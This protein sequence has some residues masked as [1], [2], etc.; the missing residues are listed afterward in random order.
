MARKRA[1]EIYDE[2]EDLTTFDDDI[3]DADDDMSLNDISSTDN[4]SNELS[5]NRESIYR[6]HRMHFEEKE[7]NDDNDDNI[8][9]TRRMVD[10]E[11]SSNDEKR[12]KRENY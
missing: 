7:K 4:L 3:I 1:A 8:L 6:H 2:E 11:I 5:T 12:V 9:S 10:D